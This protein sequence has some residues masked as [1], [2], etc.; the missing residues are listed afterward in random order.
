ML[1]DDTDCVALPPDPID[2]VV[3][4]AVAV[5]SRAGVS[6]L[7]V[8]LGVA[9]A[10]LTRDGVCEGWVYTLP[11]VI[12][13]ASVVGDALTVA[14]T[15]SDGPTLG[16][17]EDLLGVSDFRPLPGRGGVYRVWDDADG[18]AVECV[19]SRTADTAYPINRADRVATM[20]LRP[21]L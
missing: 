17:V 9:P 4:V 5:R 18:V 12:G 19:L 8:A 20:T 10:E 14:V 3:A 2:V 16:D 6:P 13:A 11:G 21:A 7:S 1:G 15:F